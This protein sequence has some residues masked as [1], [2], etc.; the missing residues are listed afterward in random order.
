MGEFHGFKEGRTEI[1]PFISRW[2]ATVYTYFIDMEESVF[3]DGCGILRSNPFHPHPSPLPP[4]GEGVWENHRLAAGRR[5]LPFFHK[6][7]KKRNRRSYTD[8]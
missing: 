3:R 4:A 8:V 2:R 7:E 5:H 1:P 6:R